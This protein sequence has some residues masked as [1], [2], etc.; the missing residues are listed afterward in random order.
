[1]TSVLCRVR[2]T[3]WWVG[4]S[5]VLLGVEAGRVARAAEVVQ[6]VPRV[7]PRPLLVLHVSAQPVERPVLAQ[8]VERPVLAQAVEWPVLAQAAQWQAPRP[9]RRRT[10][11]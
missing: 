6:V 8:P 11:P 9:E 3:G 5:G 1:M 10:K 4:A 2:V 7:V